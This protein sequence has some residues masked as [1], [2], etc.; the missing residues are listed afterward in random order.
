[1]SE[2][3]VAFR[4]TLDRRPIFSASLLAL[5]LLVAACTEETPPASAA[6]LPHQFTGLA[7][8][9]TDP[10]D[11]PAGYDYPQPANVV[12]QW[13]ANRDDARARGHGWALWA[14]L[15]VPAANGQPVWRTWCTSTQAFALPTAA[16][17]A[18][19]GAAPGAAAP[20]AGNAARAQYAAA[21]G[22]PFHRRRSL[23]EIR[24]AASL[25]GP[26]EDPINLPNAPVYPVPAAVRAAYPQ[27][28]VAATADAPEHLIDGPTFQNNEDIM[29]AGVIYNRPAYDWIRQQNLF[30]G[31]TLNALRPAPGP[32]IGAMADMPAG[33]I[34]LKPMMWPVQGDGYTA[35]PLWDDLPPPAE[36]GSY[37]GFEIQRLWSRAVAVTAQQPSP[38]GNVDVSYLNGVLNADG[39]PLGPNTYANAPVV[40]IDSFYTFQFPDLDQMDACDRAILDASAWWAYGRAFAPGDYLALIAMHIM[41]KEQPAW[42]FQS[43]WWHD[44]PDAGAHGGPRPASLR[45]AGPWGN[46]RLASTYGIPEQPNGPTWPIA[47][48]PYIELAAD[49][50]IRTNCMNCHH[51]AAWPRQPAEVPP[52][53]TRASYEAAQLL[54]GPPAP[55]AL[56]IFSLTD[57]IFYNLVLV[58][59]IWS[60]SDRAH[61]PPSQERQGEVANA[62][63]TAPT[64]PSPRP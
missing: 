40:G 24:R 19:A 22:H 59:S 32:N 51:R 26:V 53:L 37:A 10:A 50:P 36:E 61:L 1:M 2:L 31:S 29:V 16:A 20:A 21:D 27:C 48:N 30:Q 46:Y 43:V 54:G 39:S 9:C 28:Y 35:L 42:T 64:P 13:V 60:I 63:S 17:A 12:Q 52:P 38:A 58:D 18:P 45:A 5:T 44:Q 49:H 62:S 6:A 7:Q 34:V 55:D 41:T 15:N 11:F 3:K 4:R 8:V 33:S 56:D 47:Y 23:N 25:G 14:G 57:P